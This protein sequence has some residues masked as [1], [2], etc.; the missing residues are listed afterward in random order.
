MKALFLSHEYSLAPGGGGQQICTREYADSLRR[1]GFSLTN[2]LFATDRRWATR[3]RRRIQPAPYANL[4]PDEYLDRIAQSVRSHDPSHVFCNLYNF[5]PLGPVLRALLPRETR[6]VLL[7]H[8]LASVD[9]VHAARIA[10]HRADARLGAMLRIEADGLPAFDHVFTLAPFEVE[11]TRWLGAR[12]VSWVPRMLSSKNPLKWAPEGTRVGCVGTFDHPPNLE[13]LEL[14]CSALQQI[15]PGRLRLRVVTRSHAVLARLRS[16]YPF[17]DDL[18]PME[19]ASALEAEAGT[20][21]AFLH[22]LFCMAMGCSTKL[23]TAINWGLPVLTTPAGMRG[24]QWKEGGVSLANT[25]GELAQNALDALDGN[26]AD[27][28]RADVLRAA[29]SAPGLDEIAKNMRQALG[30]PQSNSI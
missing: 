2:V 8:G 9:E 19:E 18:G 20:W 12:S 28:L 26:R 13:G 29:R 22:P 11:I 3:L 30:V 24:Y 1:A 21:N 23:A 16:S 7:S 25:P 17:I 6:L 5:I 14:L 15:G 27:A 4:I 10:R